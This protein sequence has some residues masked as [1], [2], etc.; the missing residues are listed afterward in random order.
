MIMS[1]DPPTFETDTG[2]RKNFS[3]NEVSNKAQVLGLLNYKL[4]LG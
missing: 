4:R 2:R 3:L 1:K